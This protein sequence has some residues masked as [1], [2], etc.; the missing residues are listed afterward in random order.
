VGPTRR[1]VLLLTSVALLTAAMLGVT[2]AGAQQDEDAPAPPVQGVSTA[3]LLDRLDALELDL[4]GTTPPVDVEVGPE[5]TWGTLGGD[6]GSVQVVLETLQADLRRLFVDADDAEGPV[7]AA[8]ATVARGWLDVWQ[9]TAALTLWETHDLAFPRE[10]SDAAGV[11]TGADELYG[12]AEKGLELVLLGRARHLEGYAALVELGE[13]EPDAQARIDV[14]ASEAA[15][16]DEEI[17]PRV[18]ALLS[19]PSTGV[20]VATDRF[21]TA[22]PGVAPRA[23]S[24][25]FVCVDRALFAALGP[26]PTAE[27]LAAA[28]AAT[29]DRVDC[30]DLPDLPDL[31]EPTAG[32]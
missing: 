15:V 21:D 18:L 16:F 14:R 24:L 8:V 30:P 22:A 29:P 17:R 3:E 9:G 5:T 13:A 12:Q 27:E 25:A 4:P 28:V 11:A 1:A 6:P 31:T 32:S 10:A 2:S 19:Q 26:E 23:T 20:L 7:A